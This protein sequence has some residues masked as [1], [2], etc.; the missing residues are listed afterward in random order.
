MPDTAVT[1]DFGPG[2]Y[3]FWLPM[4]RIVEI[5]RLCGGKSILTMHDELGGAM[6]LGDDDEPTFIGGGGGRI[7]DVYE[8]IRCAAI[9]G[10]E[11]ELSGAPVK[12][13]AIDAK[14]LVDEY[15]DGQPLAETIPV[16]W[17]ILDAAIR[18]VQLKK[19]AVTGSDDTSQ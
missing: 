5:E 9:G 10:G 8:V 12:V 19:K 18:G 11:A 6:G 4:A 14:V 17:A 15:V 1:L 3:R 2:R 16:A 13:S 7:R